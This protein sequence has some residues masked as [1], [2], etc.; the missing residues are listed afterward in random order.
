MPH[1]L[2]QR[3]ES[4]V[5]KT[6]WQAQPAILI[7]MRLLLTKHH[8]LGAHNAQV[9]SP[10]RRHCR[11]AWAPRAALTTKTAPAVPNETTTERIF[12]EMDERGASTKQGEWC[13]LAARGAGSSQPLVPEPQPARIK[14]HT[15]A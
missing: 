11:A 10:H 14:Q 3:A 1:A 5:A 7:A 13:T 15:W 2:L 12:R 9:R 4:R 8:W 6:R